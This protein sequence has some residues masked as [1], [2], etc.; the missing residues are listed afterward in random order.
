MSHASYMMFSGVLLGPGEANVGAVLQLP[1][2]QVLGVDAV[3]IVDGS[4]PLRDANTGRSSPGQVT[5]GVESNVAEALHDVRL[6][7]PARRLA[8]H[9]HVMRLLDEVVDP[10]EDATAIGRGPAVDSALIDRL[11][12]H[13]GRCI[14]IT[15][16]NCVCKSIGYLGH[17]SLPCA[18]VGGR[19]VN[20][21]TQETLFSQL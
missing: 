3:R 19:Y 11:A 21:R 5:T 1:V 13:T 9:R 6:A 12:R 4:V 15:V 7:A 18:H 8:Y 20:R 10:M 16:T 14:E 2:L 17:L